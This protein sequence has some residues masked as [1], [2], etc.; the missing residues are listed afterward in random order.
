M[1]TDAL[2]TDKETWHGMVHAIHDII[3]EERIL[4]KKQAKKLFSV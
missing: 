3:D 2:N 1:F 4:T